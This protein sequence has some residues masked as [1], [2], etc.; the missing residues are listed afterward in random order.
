MTK[1]AKTS[2]RHDNQDCDR[3]PSLDDPFFN[4]RGALALDRD[5]AGHRRF[6][7]FY[8]DMLS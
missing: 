6:A 8:E 3:R 7:L 4:Q 1:S 2:S 5:R